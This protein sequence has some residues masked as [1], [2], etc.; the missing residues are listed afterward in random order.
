MAQV[1]RIA[2]LREEAEHTE[3]RRRTH[4]QRA[5]HHILNDRLT[6][7]AITVFMF[8]T[9]ASLF[10]PVI[11]GIIGVNPE[12]ENLNN[13]YKL[14]GV[15]VNPSDP[16][17]TRIHILGTDDKGRDYLSR[18][19]YGGRVSLA[20]AFSAAIL[21]LTI[22]VSLGIYTGYYG[23][24]VDDILIWFITTL[25]SIPQLFLLL[26]ISAILSP[27][28]IVF[29]AI[30]GLLGWT[31]T[32]RLVRGETLAL[33]EREYIIAARAMGA[34]DIRVMF[35]HILPNLISIVVVTLA[36]DIGVLILIESALSYLSFGVPPPTPT[37]GNM[38]TDAQQFMSRVPPAPHLVIIPGVLITITV[39]C[40]Y[41]IGDGLRDALDPTAQDR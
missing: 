29:I 27:S 5:I 3:F 36:I 26:I 35:Q 12:T 33:R 20:I 15:S 23:G 7:I 18:L 28:P 39:L 1:D 32:M 13:T 16:D 14:P 22:G 21:S 4:T 31:G 24:V 10:A 19:L 40:L 37:W 11:T 17:E 8:M 2:T 38:L 9:L 34:S 6:L 30:L 41:I 25:N